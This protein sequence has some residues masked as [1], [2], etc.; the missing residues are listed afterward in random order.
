MK[1]IIAYFLPVTSLFVILLAAG[2]CRNEVDIDLDKGFSSQIQQIVPQSIIDSLRNK[3]MVINE[4]LVPPRID[5][6]YFVDENILQVPYGP[7]D[8]YK[9]GALF[10]SYYYRFYDQDAT[11]NI[12]YDF[13]TDNKRDYGV[14]KGAFI[15]GNGNKFT[16]FS[17]QIGVTDNIPNKQLTVIS[18][19]LTDEGII[20]WQNSFIITDKTG[21]PEDK[22]VIAVGKG[23]IFTD[24]D[25]LA[26]K[27]IYYPQ[28]ID[29]EVKTARINATDRIPTML[30][31]K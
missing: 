29:P 12:K 5:N 14:G 25:G 17:E 27:T 15:S 21:D 2:G 16:I 24:G 31:A 23:R 11:G 6:I 3:G 20:G 18:G 7:D 13:S 28:A 4:G 26:T 19:E 22:I 1:N 10:L 8:Y 30:S 9:S